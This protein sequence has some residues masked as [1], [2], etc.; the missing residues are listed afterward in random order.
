METILEKGKEKKDR[1][2]TGSQGQA[3]EEGE[4]AGSDE[5]EVIGRKPEDE[6]SEE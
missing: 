4:E 5:P 3:P 6:D 2:G 1:T